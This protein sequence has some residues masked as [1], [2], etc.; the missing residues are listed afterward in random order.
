[1]NPSPRHS[2]C[3]RSANTCAISASAAGLP[4]SATTRVYWF[5]TS[6]RPSRIW[7]SSIATEARMSSGSN[8]ATT[9]GF[10]YTS[11]TNR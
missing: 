11:G 8:P 1:M 2:K 7:A 4:C 5:S 6:Q 9:I 3:G 10:P